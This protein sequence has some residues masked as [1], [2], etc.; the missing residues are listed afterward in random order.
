MCGVHGATCSLTRRTALQPH[1]E[2]VIAFVYYLSWLRFLFHIVIITHMHRRDNALSFTSFDL[3]ATLHQHLCTLIKLRARCIMQDCSMIKLYYIVTLSE[4]QAAINNLNKY[5]LFRCIICI[6]KNLK[7]NA[8]P[9][10][11]IIIPYCS[12]TL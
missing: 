10:A 9:L 7:N 8:N 5:W 12:R 3:C 11:A 4:C 6:A 1:A 2:Y